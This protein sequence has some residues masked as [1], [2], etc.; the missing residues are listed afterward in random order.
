M[1]SDG[2]Q[3]SGVKPG[4]IVALCTERSLELVVGILGILKAGAAYLPLDPRDPKER[5][6]FMLAD[7]AASV[8][9][10][11]KVAGTTSGFFRRQNPAS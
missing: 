2:L 4:S 7:T 11:H 9:L 5:L 1:W 10:T 3:F 6:E 8:L